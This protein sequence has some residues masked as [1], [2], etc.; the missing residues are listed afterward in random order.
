MFRGNGEPTARTAVGIFLDERFVIWKDKVLDQSSPCTSL[1]CIWANTQ[2]NINSALFSGRAFVNVLCDYIFQLTL[3]LEDVLDGIANGTFT[4]A[5]VGDDVR[6]VF[7]FF[8][9]IGDRDGKTSGAH[10]G[11]ID[12]VVANE[13]GLIGGEVLYLENLAHGG[14]LVIC[15]LI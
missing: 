10:G 2:Q 7:Y 8:A 14:E 6:L 13:C 3:S 11:K 1:P 9:G 4:S 15:S 12:N 5:M